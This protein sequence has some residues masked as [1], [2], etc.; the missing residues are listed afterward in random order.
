M[1]APSPTLEATSVVIRRRRRFVRETPPSFQ[2]TPRDIAL[3]GLVAQHRFLN[4][5]Q[6]SE[7]VQAPHKK[8]CDR[9]ALLF[10]AGYLDRPRAQFEAF[11]EGG[12]SASMAYALTAGGRRL[13]LEHGAELPDV[14][15]TRKNQLAGRQYIAHTLA[16]ADMHVA[17]TRS[18]R[19]HP[20][21]RLLPASQLLKMAPPESARR[22]QPWS[23]AGDVRTEAGLQSMSVVPDY[24]FGIGYPDR[25]FRAYLV[26]CDR[27]TMPVDRGD[28]RQTS[29]KRKLLTYAAARRQGEHDRRFGW[30]AFRVL[31]ITSS[32]QRAENTLACIDDSL[33]P[34][35][36]SLFLVTDHAVLEQ[37]DVLLAGWYGHRR[38]QHALI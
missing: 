3:I 1:P 16:I 7:L 24:V 26:E 9:L 22:R 8:V 27:G 2:V 21:L 30:K 34:L 32:R 33:D 20:E 10:H 6:L 4:S 13:L 23:L 25:R 38:L 28:L 11:R 29:L 36:R 35:D 31:I 12:G 19:Q 17:L 14:D 5:T 15:W 18:A 37:S